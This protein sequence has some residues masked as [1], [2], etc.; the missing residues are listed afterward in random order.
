VPAQYTRQAQ[1]LRS[2]GLQP[3]C[4]M[5]YIMTNVPVDLISASTQNTRGSL[6]AWLYAAPCKCDAGSTH[7]LLSLPLIGRHADALDAAAVSLDY[8]TAADVKK[9]PHFICVISS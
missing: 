9:M 2:T 1:L 5:R 7:S 4:L 8:C 6:V 3:A